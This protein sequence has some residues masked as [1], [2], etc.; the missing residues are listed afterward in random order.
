MNELG[1]KFKKKFTCLG[2]NTEKYITFT[3]PNKKKLQELKKMEK[4]EK[5]YLTYYNLL[6]V[7][8][9][10]QAHCQLLSINFSGGINRTKCK[11]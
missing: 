5:I 3:V 11:N 2:E 8:D 7:L 4:S 6:I 9:L 1:K 10:W